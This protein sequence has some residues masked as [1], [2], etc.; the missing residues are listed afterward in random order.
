MRPSLVDLP[1][2]ARAG[3][4]RLRFLRLC[5]SDVPR[6][7]CIR[8]HRAPQPPLGPLQRHRASDCGLDPATTAGGGRVPR[9]IPIL[10]PQSRRHLRES[11]RR[12]DRQARNSSIEIPATLP[13]G[14]CDLRTSHRHNSPGVPE[15][16]DPAVGIPTAAHSQIVDHSLQ[17]RAPPPQNVSHTSTPP[18]PPCWSGVVVFLIPPTCPPPPPPPPPPGGGRGP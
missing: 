5:H 6:A 12:V 11:S 3:N 13:A 10:A 2:P 4:H 9:A 1:A 8:G 18:P 16:V 7:V 15:L 14:E 17:H